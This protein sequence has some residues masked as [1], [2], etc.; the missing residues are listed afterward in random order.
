MTANWEGKSG[1]QW[2][3]PVGGGVGRLFKL[4]GQPIDTQIQA[5]SDVEKP[6]R[7]SSDWELRFQFKFLF[8]E[9]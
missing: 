6:T 9:K 4:G 5:F 3:V 7:S 1:Q 2:T 8:P